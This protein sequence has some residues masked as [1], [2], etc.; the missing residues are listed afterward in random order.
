M[1][2]I[3]NGKQQ[4]RTEIFLDEDVY[5]ALKAYAK[6]NGFGLSVLVNSILKQELSKLPK[7]KKLQ[8]VA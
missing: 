8:K 3:R 6:A 4:K 5:Q 7:Q 1:P 2:M